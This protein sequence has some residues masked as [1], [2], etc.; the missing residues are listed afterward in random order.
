ME[1]TRDATVTAHL[2][3]GETSPDVPKSYQTMVRCILEYAS[4]SWDPHSTTNIEKYIEAVQ[5]RAA[6]F[7]CGGGYKTTS[8]PSQMTA[9]LGWETMCR[10]S[11]KLVVMY[12]ITYGLIDIPGPAFLHPGLNTE[13]QRQHTTLPCVLQQDRRLPAFHSSHLQ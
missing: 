9:D 4:T 3:S 10:A 7:S 2:S 5:R 1:C 13:N 11:A 8:S 12:R 6:R